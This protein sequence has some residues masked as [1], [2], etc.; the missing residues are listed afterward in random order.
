[1]PAVLVDADI[2][3]FQ[4]ASLNEVEYQWDEELASKVIDQDRAIDDLEVFIRDLKKELKA[5]ETIFCF[6]TAP[7]W[8]YDV[9]PSY[10]SNRKKEKPSLFYQL[11]DHVLT[12][13]QCKVKP[14]L[15]AD[16]VIGIMATLKPGKYIIAS[17]DKDLNQIPGKHF[18][19]RTGEMTNV[20]LEEAD[21]FFYRQVLTGDPTDGYPGCPGIGPKT[22][23]R[24]LDDAG[25]N[26]WPVI[27]KTYEA[28]GLTEEDALVQARVARILR[29]TEYDFKA[30]KPKLWVPPS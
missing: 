14:S 27:V 2:V 17:I 15:E 8:R 25:E 18:N 16:D 29:K 26:P 22:A 7:N 9:Y 10:K 6:S 28:K 21:R 11:K 12:N 23:D 3:C 13:Y 20:S 19:W 24:I 30:K 5:E 4:F 1:M